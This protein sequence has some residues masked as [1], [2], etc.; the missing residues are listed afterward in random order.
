MQF[1]IKREEDIILIPEI[2]NFGTCAEKS[3]FE[4]KIGQLQHGAASVPFDENIQNA[5]K[6]RRKT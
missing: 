4:R 2:L 6:A 5:P 1:H 3:F